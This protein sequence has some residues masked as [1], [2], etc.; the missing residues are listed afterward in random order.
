MKI[1]KILYHILDFIFLMLSYILCDYLSNKI[2]IIIGII[3]GL[4]S[5]MIINFIIKKLLKLK[6]NEYGII[7]REE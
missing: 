4:I 1:K 5:Y 3:I 7:E 6:E 2:N